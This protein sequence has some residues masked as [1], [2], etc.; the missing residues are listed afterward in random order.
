MGLGAVLFQLNEENKMKVISYNS[1]NLNPQ[2]QKLSTP[3]CE[4]I[5]I[6]NALQIYDLISL[7]LRIQS[8]FSQLINL[9]Y[10]VLQKSNLSSQFYCAQVKLTKFPKLKIIHTP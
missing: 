7:D 3:D 4:L 9:F 6:V 10:T 8:T 2:E 1:R 5:G